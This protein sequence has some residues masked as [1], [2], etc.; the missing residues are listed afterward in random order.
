MPAVGSDE[1]FYTTS[2]LDD[3]MTL[4]L[5]N[6]QNQDSYTYTGPPS[7]SNV[8]YLSN[9]TVLNADG[10]TDLS[11]FASISFASGWT[12]IV[13]HGVLFEP[14]FPGG[15]IE[16]VSNVMWFVPPDVPQ[17]AIQNTTITHGSA[18]QN[19]TILNFQ[20]SNRNSTLNAWSV[21][22][23]QNGTTLKQFTPTV[24]PRGPGV[25]NGDNPLNV[26]LDWDGVV[27]GD[28][29][30]VVTA[31]TTDFVAGGPVND[32]VNSTQVAVVQS[33]QTINVE[34]LAADPVAFDPTAHEN[35]T[36]SFNVTTHGLVRPTIKWQVVVNDERGQP[37]VTFPA[38][39]RPNADT[40]ESVVMPTWLGNNTTGNVIQGDF[41]W[42]VYANT[43]TAG[44]Q[45]LTA[46]LA[47]LGGSTAASNLTITDRRTSTLRGVASD[48]ETAN[49]TEARL[50]LLSDVYPQ[51]A[52][53]VG[54]ETW[55]INATHLKFEGNIAP[56][57]I[58]A[59]L[60]SSVTH[61]TTNT[62]LTYNNATK[63]YEGT[64][65]LG[66]G[67][68]NATVGESNVTV[69]YVQR[70]TGVNIAQAA[71]A[72]PA[73][74]KLNLGGL[75]EKISL[76]SNSTLVK[77]D[78]EKPNLARSSV[79]NT[80]QYGFETVN[81]TLTAPGLKKPLHALVKARHPAAN[82]ESA[83]DYLAL[84][85]HGYHSGSLILVNATNAN[86]SVFLD[87]ANA[88][89]ARTRLPK[90]ILSMAC[91][92]FDLRDYNNFN[93][94]EH[95]PGTHAANATRGSF[96]GEAWYNVANS[97][98]PPTVLLG[99]NGWSP[100]GPE[101]GFVG[102][103][104]AATGNNTAIILDWLRRNRTAATTSRHA[105]A[106]ALL[107]ACAYDTNGD[108]YYIAY[109]PLPG[110]YTLHPPPATRATPA[111]GALGIYKIPH[112]RWGTEAKSWK[113]IPQQQRVGAGQRP[114]TLADKV[115]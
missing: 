31:N 45:L 104:P 108:Y 107:N 89:A 35:S 39:S 32:G 101:L 94:A 56:T 49:A 28:Y 76:S 97:T 79:N 8:T 33:A 2:L 92:S 42:L 34:T 91:A 3:G 114:K 106:W 69:N 85:V 5:R 83:V 80:L 29:N 44:G 100:A 81:V 7:G 12:A 95:Y 111:P 63:A 17:I 103:K 62:T 37:F 113:L 51:D 74:N 72:F 16:Q 9:E 59:V 65:T 71:Q 64:I 18:A 15:G 78:I 98:T 41:T 50:K 112:D 99:Y 36:L 1:Q 14:D 66:P 75:L 57:T 73:V 54:Q 86:A 82:Y 25:T 53:I 46:P 102:S 96:G 115:E 93:S 77:D 58:T 109:N 30:F 19:A 67:L 84:D 110:T 21:A 55:A 13:G 52:T 90:I 10:T 24:D 20:I 11:W 105:Y 88:Q 38:D 27:T 40:T 68:V 47:Q 61:G 23:V 22:A 48:P 4:S 70:V 43:T 6:N 87:P 26:S 60:N